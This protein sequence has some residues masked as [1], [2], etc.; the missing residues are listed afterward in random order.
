ML[1]SFQKLFAVYVISFSNVALAVAA[2]S[3]VIYYLLSKYKCRVGRQIG[4][5]ALISEGKHSMIRLH[6][7]LGFRWRFP[8]CSWL[9]SWGGC[10]RFSHWCL[11]VD[12]RVII[13]KSGF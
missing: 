4:S 8:W 11:R 2:L 13:W 5:Q 7:Y 1:E 6:F 9:S 3:T 12:K 10:D